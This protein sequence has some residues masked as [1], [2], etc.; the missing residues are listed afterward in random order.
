MVRVARLTCSPQLARRLSL[1]GRLI[2]DGASAAPGV[3]P[4]WQPPT[5]PRR[6]S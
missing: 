4:L 5:A 2:R 3:L 1:E 6:D